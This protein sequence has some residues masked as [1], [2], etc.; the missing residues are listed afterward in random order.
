MGSFTSFGGLQPGEFTG[1]P[2]DVGVNAGLSGPPELVEGLGMQEYNPFPVD[3]H[4]KVR[5][6]G[7]A[8]GY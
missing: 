1:F 7:Q 8:K 2:K 6:K 5:H 3:E 4:V